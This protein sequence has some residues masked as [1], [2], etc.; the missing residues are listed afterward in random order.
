MKKGGEEN[1]GEMYCYDPY[2]SSVQ[3]KKKGEAGK[4]NTPHWFILPR[5][6]CKSSGG[7]GVTPNIYKAYPGGGEKRK[8]RTPVR[9]RKGR[10]RMGE[11][12]LRCVVATSE[13]RL[14]LL[15]FGKG[16]GKKRSFKK[17]GPL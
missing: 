8:E 16:G 1:I 13:K 7:G 6:G 2:S 4:V 3:G 10:E 12:E 9:R 11:M 15:L 17:K 5:R 14:L